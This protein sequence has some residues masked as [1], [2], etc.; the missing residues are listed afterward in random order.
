MLALVLGFAVPFFVAILLNEFRHAQGY[1]RVLV[2]LPVML[3]P[4]LGLLLFKYFYDPGDGLFNGILRHLHLPT[5][6]WLQSPD[7]GLPPWRCSPW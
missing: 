5:S 2:Y 1:L 4:R 6:Q 3:P 7:T